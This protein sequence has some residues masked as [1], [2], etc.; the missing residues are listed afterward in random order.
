MAKEEIAS[1]VLV[2]QL[3]VYFKVIVIQL[4]ISQCFPQY[5]HDYVF[6]TLNKLFMI[7]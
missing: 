1:V 7:R 2:S 3:R 4:S 5:Y 6:C